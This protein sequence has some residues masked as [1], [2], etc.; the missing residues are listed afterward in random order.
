V[1]VIDSFTTDFDYPFFDGGGT[2]DRVP[3]ALPVAIQGHAYLIDLEHYDRQTLDFTRA[4]ADTAAEPGEQ[5][6]NPE[7]LWRRS[8]HDWTSG[9]GQALADGNTM[10]GSQSFQGRISA[11]DRFR[12]SKGIDNW[13]QGQISLLPDT[14]SVLSSAA[15]NLKLL[16]VGGY[17]YVADNQ[18]LRY[19]TDGTS[20]TTVTGTPAAAIADIATNGTTLWVAYAANGIY[21]GTVGGASVASVGSSPNV[22]MLRFANGRL[23]GALAN[24]VFEVTFAGVIATASLDYT[25]PETGFR[26]AGAAGGPAAIYLWGSAANAD[27][28][29]VYRV[30]NVPGTGALGTPAIAAFLPDGELLYDLVFYTGLFLLGTSDGLRLAD[31]DSS[32]NLSYGPVIPTD[33]PVRCLEPQDRFCWFGATDYDATSTGLYRADLSTFTGTLIPAYASDLMATGQGDVT[34]VVSF[35]FRRFFAVSGLGVY[36]QDDNVVASGTLES[37]AL[38]W[39]TGE[40]KN[41]VSMTVRHHA[42]PAG[43]TVGMAL[44]VD[45]GDWGPA[46]TSTL[47]GSSG[48]PTSFS[49]AGSSG[50][51]LELR[52][53]LTRAT[54]A[55]VSPEAVS[56]TLKVL[57][58]PE[59]I[60]RIVVPIVMGTVVVS[61]NEVQT[62]YDPVAE[63]EFLRSLMQ[64]GTILSYQEGQSVEAAFIYAMARRPHSWTGGYKGFNGLLA[65]TLQ[66]TEVN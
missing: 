27:H 38:R 41:A 61:G 8:R 45:N 36:R 14:A 42:L 18:T 37:G 50:V 39:R 12:T 5:A 58:T 19:S 31:P 60:D 16:S 20:W 46:Q 10:L 34:S 21:S 23:I 22:S 26:W 52:L 13:T 3:G 33:W 11:V 9:A 32:G 30:I 44:K 63:E 51:T 35:G 6:L 28:S 49:T 48:P 43:A 25:H 4:Q 7:G 2:S 53:T 29:E 1:T 66:T 55:T 65:V 47:A 57:P 64:A 56:W 40:V 17:L 54:D 59:R 24:R 15:T 62:A